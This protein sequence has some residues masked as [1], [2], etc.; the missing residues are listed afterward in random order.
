MASRRGVSQLV[1]AIGLVAISL[2]L[3][4]YVAPKYLSFSKNSVPHPAPTIT[5]AKLVFISDQDTSADIAQS[6]FKLEVGV[7]NQESEETLRVCMYALN[8][9]A[10][11]SN[12]TT[13]YKVQVP[14]SGSTSD[15]CTYLHVGVGFHT[16]SILIKVPNDYLARIGCASPVSCPENSAWVVEFYD[17]QGKRIASV[18][19][20]YIV[21]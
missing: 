9:T 6:V 8:L 4:A 21:P 1:V 19:P 10:V 3:A 16:Y 14:I 2:F 17:T 11:L 13:N 18:K 7:S 12:S 5:Y 15:W 20:I